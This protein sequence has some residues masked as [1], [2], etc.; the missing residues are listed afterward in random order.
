MNQSRTFCTIITNNYFSWA[1][2]LYESLLEFDKEISLH[3]AIVDTG[4]EDHS[5]KIAGKNITILTLNDFENIP[6]SKEMI[7]K[8]DSN[9]S[10]LRW[11]LKPLLMMKCLESYE[12]VIF[13]DADIYFFASYQ[14]LFESLDHHSVIL[15]P[16]WRTLSPEKNPV[17]FYA[18]FRHGIY[19][20]GFIGANVNAGKALE[21]WAENCLAACVNDSEKGLYYDQIYLN[22][23]PVY[24]EN[25]Q[26]LKHQGCNVASWNIEVCQ[27]TWDTVT[28]EIK[29][30]NKFPVVFIHFTNVTIDKI[31][32]GED[33]LLKKHLA[34][35]NESLI[36]NGF[37][38]VV[39]GRLEYFDR[40]IREKN[41]TFSDKII[42]KLKLVY[43]KIRY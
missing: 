33:S 32:K 31:L 13:V 2:T 22:L 30:N 8:Y 36:K 5:S 11:S 21:Y 19:N 41:A 3:V 24:F 14:F 25:V 35:F 16:H 12:K 9:L 42:K 4:T 1:L 39:K 43:Y 29:I 26:I 6:F 37:K 34:K 7:R 23:I 27:R 20:A 17:E 15:T 18:T 10:T 40:L 38:D 28:Q